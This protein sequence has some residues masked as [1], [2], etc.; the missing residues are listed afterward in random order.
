MEQI[1]RTF[2]VYGGVAVADGASDSATNA[3]VS[4]TALSL[5][6]KSGGGQP[7]AGLGTHY[8]DHCD[9]CGQENRTLKVGAGCAA[10]RQRGSGPEELPLQ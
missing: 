1:R 6:G 4:Q 9:L 7:G 10:D 2:G 3:A 8:R 5:S